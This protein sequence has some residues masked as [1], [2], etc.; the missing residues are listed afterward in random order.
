VHDAGIGQRHHGGRAAINLV[1]QRI[2]AR[3]EIRELVIAA[4]VDQFLASN[5]DPQRGV[6]FL[7]LAAHR[8]PVGIGHATV[9]DLVGRIELGRGLPVF[10]PHLCGQLILAELFHDLAQRRAFKRERG[11]GLTV[12]AG[13]QHRLGQ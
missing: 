10:L 6:G 12:A 7:A 3:R 11:I 1:G 13:E 5:A 4:L 9:H 8:L 2:P